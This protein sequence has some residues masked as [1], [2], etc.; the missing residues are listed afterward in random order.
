[1][2]L[3]V[4]MASGSNQSSVENEFAVVLLP[5]SE[6]EDED[7]LQPTRTKIFTSGEFVNGLLEPRLTTV[8]FYSQ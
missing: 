6:P 5:T 8:N 3:A 2:P 4:N 1:V 7:I